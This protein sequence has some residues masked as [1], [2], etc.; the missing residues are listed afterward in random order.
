MNLEILE[1][2]MAWHYEH[3]DHNKRLWEAEQSAR[4]TNKGLWTDG[5]AV[6]PWDW[7]KEHQHRKATAKP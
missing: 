2:G 1:E 3:Y 4:A 6:P 5:E 7:R